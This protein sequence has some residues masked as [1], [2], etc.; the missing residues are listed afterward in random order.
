MIPVNEPVLTDQDFE[1]LKEAFSSGWI[2]SAGKYIEQFEKKWAEYCGMTHGIS[3]SN[4]TAA[5]Q[6]ALDAAG[7]GVGDEVIMP[8]FTIISCGQAVTNLGAIPVLVDSDV[9]T[10]CMD[11]TS[12]ESRVTKK[13]K[14]IMVVHMYGHPVDMDVVMAIAKKHNILV[15]EDAAEVHGAKYL[16]N[17]G[18]SSEKW[19]VCGG[20]GDISTFSFFA[21]KLITTGE[22]GMVLTSDSGINDRAMMLRNLCFNNERR[23]RHYE[24]GYN[25]RLTNMQ[26]A[27]GVSQIQRIE[28]IVE[29]KIEIGRY[30]QEQLSQI[31]GIQL[32]KQE[33][34][35]KGVFW[36]N[37]LVL[38]DSLNCT[39][40]KFCDELRK[41]G[42]DT[43]PF[44]LGMHEQPV[45]A[46][47]GLFI[48]EKYPVS[49]RIAKQGFYLPSGLSLTIDQ[50]DE[51]INSFKL[52][53]EKI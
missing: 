52:V 18:T 23:F 44:F 14:A 25:Y 22:G 27:I 49:E 43:R 34:W 13:T 38:D 10:W 12:I 32:Q 53:M 5:I 47:K 8:S 3:V 30:Y 35:A 26:A 4:G 16:S 48:G 2:S 37:G 41:L 33:S 29:R 21:N 39:A 51:V 40:E 17:R 9:N 50:V 1:Y 46:S 28:E 24:L 19:L 45:F 20:I 11:V 42:V 15:I 7:I 31:E 6:L 36:I